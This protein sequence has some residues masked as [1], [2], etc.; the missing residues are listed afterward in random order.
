[1]QTKECDLPTLN[2]FNYSTTEM[3]EHISATSY[4]NRITEEVPNIEKLSVGS[5]NL[6]A[7]S[8]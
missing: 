2:I 3:L 1:M 6:Q 5:N 4:E 8:V 7:L